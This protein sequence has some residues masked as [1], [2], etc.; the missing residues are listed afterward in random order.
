[1][2]VPDALIDSGDSFAG[3][4]RAESL[5]LPSALSEPELKEERAEKPQQ[6]RRGGL[7]G[8]LFK[9]ADLVLYVAG[10]PA[11]IERR[12]QALGVSHHV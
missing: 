5:A 6:K 1:M 2:L 12:A 3:Q 10:S 9:A 8:S 7:F 11:A 4:V